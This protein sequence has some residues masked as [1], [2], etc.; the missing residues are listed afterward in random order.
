[1]SA[2]SKDETRKRLDYRARHRGTKEMDIILGGFTDKRLAGLSPEEL[3]H[4]EQILS[5]PDTQLYLWISGRAPIPVE[6]DC[7]LLQEIRL[8][9][10]KPKK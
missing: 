4:F 3:K 6:A 7:P 10:L 1:M 5:Y 2:S 9:A 8:S